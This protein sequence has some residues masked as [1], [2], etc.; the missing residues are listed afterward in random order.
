MP[1]NRNIEIG[2]VALCNLKADKRYGK[3]LVI[4][5]IIDQ[6]RVLVDAPGVKRDVIS[7]RRVA[8]TDL[9]VDIE[10]ACDGAALEAAMKSADVAG[11]WAASAW[12]KKI[13]RQDARANLTDFERF[14]VA[15]ARTKRSA[16]VKK[17]LAA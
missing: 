13:A 17:A 14:K 3:L 11:K 5:D 2:R 15:V 1:F 16:L 10:R 4:V 7:L 8:I 9:K 6:N 12:G